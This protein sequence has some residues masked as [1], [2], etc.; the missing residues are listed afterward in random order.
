M[1]SSVDQAARSEY[2]ELQR[3]G[4]P[5]P[6]NNSYA[7]SLTRYPLRVWIPAP[8]R[9]SG[10]LRRRSAPSHTQVQRWILT[11]SHLW[12]YLLCSRCMIVPLFNVIRAMYDH[13]FMLTMSHWRYLQAGEIKRQ[14]EAAR[15]P[16]SH[17]MR[18]SNVVV[19]Q[20][21]RARGPCGASEAHGPGCGGGPRLGVLL[22]GKSSLLRVLESRQ[23]A[24]CLV[25]GG[26]VS[27]Y[28]RSNRIPA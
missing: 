17:H 28:T 19:R 6:L 7:S 5:L 18:P 2:E 9:S 11:W 13:V 14:V 15:W 24:T 27:I 3:L 23:G 22:F 20:R 8:G 12:Q 10:P 21:S 4:S 25:S 16:G 1:G 26:H